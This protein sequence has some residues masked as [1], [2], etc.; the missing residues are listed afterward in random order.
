M[1]AIGTAGWSIPR[2]LLPPFLREEGSGLWRYSHLFPITEINRTFYHLPRPSTFLRWRDETPDGFRFS[3]K[4]SRKIT[5]TGRLRAHLE[6]L[7]PFFQ[8]VTLLGE[9]LYGVLIQLPPSLPFNL[10]LIEGFLETIHSLYRGRLFL[11]PRHPSWQRWNPMELGVTPVYADP[12]LAWWLGVPE[13]YFRLHGTPQVYHSS[14]DDNYLR[15]LASKLRDHR[16][17][18]VIFDNTASGAA[19][20]NALR[21]MEFYYETQ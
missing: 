3:V 21:L 7:E 1:V 18:A 12:G 16:E 5:H 2:E 19:F 9:K 15:S 13:P 20:K 17:A 4:L 10:P 11:E 8:R 14:Y 6:E